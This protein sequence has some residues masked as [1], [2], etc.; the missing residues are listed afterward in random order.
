MSK[1][2]NL[3]RITTEITKECR[4]QLRILA[5]HKDA[6]LAD[7]IKDILERAVNKKKAVIED[8]TTTE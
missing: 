8:S 7:T 2:D 6:T 3:V 1:N 5:L 4:K